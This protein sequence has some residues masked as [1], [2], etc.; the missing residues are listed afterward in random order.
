MP[1]LSQQNDPERNFNF[2]RRWVDPLPPSPAQQ[3]LNKLR[4]EHGNAAGTKI[5]RD[6][7]PG[8]KAVWL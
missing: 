2:R 4:R 6:E 7:L 8:K 5:F 1:D 3:R